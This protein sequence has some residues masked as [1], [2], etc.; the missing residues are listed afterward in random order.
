MP[1]NVGDALLEAAARRLMG[2]FGVEA[3]LVDPAAG[4]GDADEFVVAAGG[5]MGPAY[6]RA[7]AIREE[8]VSWGRPVTVLPQ[9]FTGP[10]E[11]PYARVFA[12][13][14]DSLRLRAD[15]RL[16]PDLALAL[17]VSAPGAPDLGEG[18]WLRA[19]GE[20]LFASAPSRGDP[21][22]ACRTPA[23][24]LRLAARH[25]HVVTDR[26][27]FAVAALLCGRRATLLPNRYHKNRA[28]HACWLDRLGCGW[29]DAPPA[30]GVPAPDPGE[31]GRRPHALRLLGDDAEPARRVFERGE[32]GGLRAGW[33][34]A[35]PTVLDVGAGVG[36]FALD[37]KL[38][39]PGAAVHCFEPD[40]AALDLLRLNL[41]PFAGV[42]VHAFGLGDPGDWGASGGPP[43]RAVVRDAAA[44]FDELSPGE[45]DVLKVSAGAASLSVLRALGPRLRAVRVALVDFRGDSDRRELAALLPEHRL[46]GAVA[47]GGAG[48]VAK[49]ARSDLP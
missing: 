36:A 32:Y 1:G 40:P 21:A 19:D 26:L 25:R 29:L 23:E 16:A 39:H 48:G 34:R 44:A 2:A 35:A 33:V 17:E 9:S 11:L 6:P 49:Y 38:R 3:R 31:A 47:R 7:V 8:V 12:R 45:V 10:D 24:Y 28:M 30:P 13:E 4:P 14:F 18:V 42:R 22:R 20:A 41:A 37:A 43:P 46:F 5:N 27:H 15:A